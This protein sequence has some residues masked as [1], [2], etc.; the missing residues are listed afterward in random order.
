MVITATADDITTFSRAK[1][2]TTS[3]DNSVE[4]GRESRERSAEWYRP[5]EE[6]VIGFLQL[7]ANWDSYGAFPIR[8]ESVERALTV[9][10]DLSLVKGIR[11]P[12]V[13]PTVSGNVGLSWEWDDCNQELDVE[14]DASRGVRYSYYNENDPDKNLEEITTY[15]LM[16]IA[17][18]LTD[19][20]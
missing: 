14:V 18:I 13:V 10:Y 16:D 4:W 1:C 12:R 6:K 17:Q 9:L 19:K 3:A 7:S 11:R 5:C 2:L 20:W 15:D 8:E